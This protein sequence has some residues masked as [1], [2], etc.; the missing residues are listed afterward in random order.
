MHNLLY[1]LMHRPV[2][3]AEYEGED[4]AAEARRRNEAA[5]AGNSLD[6][7]HA[8]WVDVETADVEDAE[9][10]ALEVL[11]VVGMDGELLAFGLASR[12]AG[13]DPQL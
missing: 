5:L 10:H 1:G 13:S 4:A 11:R 9:A 6:D 3:P 2:K 7:I 12:G 8:S